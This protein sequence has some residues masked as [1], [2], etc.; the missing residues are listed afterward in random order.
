MNCY[1]ERHAYR[2]ARQTGTIWAGT[3]KLVNGKPTFTGVVNGNPR[4][5]DL[6]LRWRRARRIFVNS[7]S[8]LFHENV[9]NETIA[10]IFGVMAAAPRHTFQV[11]TKRPAR[12][13]QWFHWHQ[14]Q[15]RRRELL[16]QPWRVCEDEAIELV[17]DLP[18]IGCAQPWP[19]SHVWLGVSVEDQAAASERIP[20]LLQTPAAVRFLSCEPLLGPVSLRWLRAFDGQALKPR[21]RCESTDHLDGL[22]RID[23]VIA[24]GES[25]PHARPMHPDWARTL[26][27]ECAAARVPFFFK[28]WGEYLPGE[29]DFD[30]SRHTWQPQEEHAPPAL[31]YERVSVVEAHGVEF[32]KVGKHRAARTLDHA[33]H[34]SY[35]ENR[36]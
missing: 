5:L 29:T 6:P 8:D 20:M 31:E 22:R 30:G 16:W 9:P 28:Q 32:G 11:L 4:A 10:A 24:G 3:A 27:D 21:A 17:P 33:E 23:W 15:V 12:M 36:A 19:L 7:M 25:G 35:P 13:L 26:R 14:E 18:A 1:A 34:N 2:F